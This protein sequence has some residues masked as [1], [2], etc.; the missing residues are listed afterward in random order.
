M[1]ETDANAQELVSIDTIKTKS[2]HAKMNVKK[3]WSSMIDTM[4]NTTLPYQG[5]DENTNLMTVILLN[6]SNGSILDNAN[7]T[8][9][10]KPRKPMVS[11]SNSGN[12]HNAEDV[13]VS[14]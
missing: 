14:W 1:L 2:R 11:A 12:V 3:V 5:M 13:Y 4:L 6:D 7:F 10:N 9:S 8:I